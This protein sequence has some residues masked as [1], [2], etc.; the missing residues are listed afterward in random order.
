MPC[1]I[2]RLTDSGLQPVDYQA[3]SL[4][5]AAAHEPDDGVYTVANTVHTY[6]VLK[7]GA[8]LARLQD[9]AQRAGIALTRQP[10]E[11]RDALR[12]LITLAGY[13]DVKFRITVPRATPNAPILSVEP[14]AGYDATLYERGVRVVTAANS[15][16]P[17]AATKDTGWMHRR[18]A[19]ERALPAG[20]STAILMDEHNQ[21]LEGTSSNFY[22]ILRDTLY[23]A[24]DGVLAGTSQQIVFE[25]AHTV[26]PLVRR[27]ITLADVP[28]LQEAFITSSSRGIVPVVQIDDVPLSG[29][30]VGAYTRALMHAYRTW[31]D[32]HLETL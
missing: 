20:V 19:L 22:A 3:D 2:R 8:H 11:L 13:G 26:L 31:V 30:E 6:D 23:T 12:A 28:Q 7:L 32:Q 15:A 29:G 1:T 5:E 18:Q 24:I 21:L 14:F 16:R 4:A 25:I 10:Q 27:P 17:N 9:S